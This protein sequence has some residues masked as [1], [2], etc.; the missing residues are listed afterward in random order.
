MKHVDMAGQFFAQVDSIQH[1]IHVKERMEE[2]FRADAGG[3]FGD[4]QVRYTFH[5]ENRWRKLRN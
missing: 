3:P 4:W 2:A 1:S 5:R